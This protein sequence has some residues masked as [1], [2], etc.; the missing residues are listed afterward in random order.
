MIEMDG[1]TL[2]GWQLPV[3]NTDKQTGS[4]W[5]PYPFELNPMQGVELPM[6]LILFRSYCENYTSR[7]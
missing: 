4:G 3:K 2:H 7:T 1:A 5:S 6:L